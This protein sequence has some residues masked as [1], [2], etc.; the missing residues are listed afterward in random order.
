MT[1]VR[2]KLAAGDRFQIRSLR[3]SPYRCT[4]IH[5]GE[6]ASGLIIRL[7]TSDDQLV[8]LD[9]ERLDWQTVARDAA[10]GPV[11]LPGDRVQLVRD[12]RPLEGKL[13]REEPGA[14]VLRAEAGEDRV[15]LAEVTSLELL[16]PARELL[17]GDRFRVRSRSGSEYRGRAIGYEPDQRLRADIDR[18]GE[19]HL[20]L[21]RL[22]LSTLYLPLPIPPAV[23]G[24]SL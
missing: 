1:L 22:D 2:P 4:F 9:P 7:A 14:L 3:G 16:Y 17:A 6:A 21:E 18:A 10:P 11:L 5:Q 13:L 15:P 23:V 8:R 19:V 20:R 12:G 24:R